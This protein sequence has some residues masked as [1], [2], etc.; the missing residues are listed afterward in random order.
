MEREH[1]IPVARG[2]NFRRDGRGHGGQQSHLDENEQLTRPR[3][4]EIDIKTAILL[5]P[6]SQ[7]VLSSMA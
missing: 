6:A 5:Q 4:M 3:G 1:R 2:I 7:A